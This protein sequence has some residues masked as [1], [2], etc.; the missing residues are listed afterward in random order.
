MSVTWTMSLISQAFTYVQA[1][2]IVH[3]EY[4]SFV[5]QLYLYKAVFKKVLRKQKEHL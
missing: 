5:Y 2:Q 1:H 3:S 4:V